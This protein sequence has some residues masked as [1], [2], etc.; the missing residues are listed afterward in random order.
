MDVW[1]F[2]VF[3]FHTGLRAS[4]CV[5]HAMDSV[6]AS[7]THLLELVPTIHEQHPEP[8]VIAESSDE[9]TDKRQ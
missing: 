5:L 4:K 8:N 6:F 3:T 7:T 2:V 1:T 9:E